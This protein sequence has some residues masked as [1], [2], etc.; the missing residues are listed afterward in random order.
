MKR[1]YDDLDPASAAAEAAD[2]ELRQ[3]Y[4]KVRFIDQ[5]KATPVRAYS[6]IVHPEKTKCL[7]F[8]GDKRGMLGM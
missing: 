4:G 2:L 6:M 8:M 1:D 7:T 5:V 3:L